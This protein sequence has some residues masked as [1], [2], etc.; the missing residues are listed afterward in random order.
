MTSVKFLFRLF[1]HH[2]T[3]HGCCCYCWCVWMCARICTNSAK[4]LCWRTRRRKN[5]LCCNNL[6]QI[7]QVAETKE[8]RREWVEG[9]GWALKWLSVKRISCNQSKISIGVAIIHSNNNS[10]HDN[11]NKSNNSNIS[12][13][14]RCRNSSWHYSKTIYNQ[15]KQQLQPIIRHSCGNM[16]WQP[17][18]AQHNG[19][20]AKAIATTLT[21]LN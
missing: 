12:G 7:T 14:L 19:R 18:S 6:K 10:K 3:S 2:A 20:N 15:Q 9:F 8:Q 21:L 4:N 1:F 16:K 11:N 13:V 5:D 17:T